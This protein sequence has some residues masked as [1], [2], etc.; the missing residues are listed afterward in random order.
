M[1]WVKLDDSFYSH[2]KVVAAGAE[3]VGLYVMALTRMA[4]AE[5]PAVDTDWVRSLPHWRRCQRRLLASGLWAASA[6]GFRPFLGDGLTPLARIVAA[7][8]QVPTWLRDLV[9]DRD[10]GVCQLC[11]AP[12][13]ADFHID[14][15]LPVVLGGPSAVGNLQLAHPTCNI[16]KGART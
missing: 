1:P 7:R 6:D 10:R 4:Q 16:R 5:A 8:E 11:G 13:G 15:I 14:H 3:A 2:P 9:L 12:V